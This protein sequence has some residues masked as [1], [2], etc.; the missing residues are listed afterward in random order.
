MDDGKMKGRVQ[1]T[2]AE[3]AWF[4]NKVY[5]LSFLFSILVVW[6]HSL[7]GELFVTGQAELEALQRLEHLAASRL[8]QIAVPGFFMISSYLFY[9]N[10]QLNNLMEKWRSRLR[11]ILLPYLLWNA[12]YYA[13]YAAVTR[14]PAI[15]QFIGKP[16]VLLTLREFMEA[17]LY[18]GYNP[19]F[20]YLFQLILLILLAPVLYLI[21]RRTISGLLFLLLLIVCLWN[22]VSLP[23]LNLDA[24]FYYSAAAFLALGRDRLGNPLEHRPS[25][26]LREQWKRS[27][28]QITMLA[29][30]F[31]LL[32]LLSIPGALLHAHPLHTV[33]I[34]LWGVC[35]AVCVIR[36]VPLP[37]AA[38]LIK[39]SFF[40][41]AVHFPW[42]RLFNKSAA[43]ILPST[44]ASA[45]FMFVMMPVFI[46]LI[47][48]VISSIMKKFLPGV[49]LLLSGG[50]GR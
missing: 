6:A 29:V 47:T 4:R 46:L 5:W 35:T 38:D 30:L 27:F 11:T 17:L 23:R 32:R 28:S 34:R 22:G 37:P 49:Y 2:A 7:N 41:Y 18:Y 31:L 24:L 9:R 42:V 25:G 8:A 10:F 19:V 3:E 12:L 14:I 50:R 15:R 26:S 20:W 13:A 40:L 39:N 36:I 21:L 44:P 33:L 1:N 43:L 45:L 48:W 16:P